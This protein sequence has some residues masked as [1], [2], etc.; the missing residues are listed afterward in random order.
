MVEKREGTRR[1]YLHVGKTDADRTK[2]TVSGLTEGNDY[3]F[4]VFAENRYG[5][6]PALETEQPIVPKRKYGK[7]SFGWYH[8]DL[9]V[10]KQ[11]RFRLALTFQQSDQCLLNYECLV[12]NKVKGEDW[13]VCIY[14]QVIW[15]LISNAWMK[16]C[17]H[18]F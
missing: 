17:S 9:T 7:T 6:S 4:K 8:M 5:T 12:L 3:N 16:F 10:C 11:G 13:S 2:L 15:I 18:C 1:S 14:A